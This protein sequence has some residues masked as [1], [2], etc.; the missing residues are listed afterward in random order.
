MIR[1]VKNIKD[2]WSQDLESYQ[3]V[4]RTLY[5]DMRNG[6]HWHEN[7]KSGTL[8]QSFDSELP[9][10]YPQ[11]V[12][13]LDLDLSLSVVAWIGLE[14]GQFAPPHQDTFYQLRKSNHDRYTIDQCLRY[15][16]FLGPWE[17]GQMVEFK[18]VTIRDW[19]AGD[20]W[21]FDH[22]EQHWACN[23]SNSCFHT[24]Q[25]NTINVGHNK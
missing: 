15:L 9:D 3:Y 4:R 11:F 13:A 18:T 25:V 14:P 8:K 23:A 20:V 17:F 19:Q 12:S 24:C 21:V 7:F 6:D 5:S 16:V 10:Y 22:T 2:F 1:F